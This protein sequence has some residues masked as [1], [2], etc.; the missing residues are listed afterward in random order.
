MG[1]PH[2]EVTWAP[3]NIQ[4]GNNFI[5]LLCQDLGGKVAG[6]LCLGVQYAGAAAGLT[7][8]FDDS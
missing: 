6:E 5:D 4:W 1:Q 8:G 7:G 3:D 2:D